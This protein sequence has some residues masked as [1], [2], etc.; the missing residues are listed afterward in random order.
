MRVVASGEPRVGHPDTPLFEC[1]RVL[2]PRT[3]DL[4]L[5]PRV[6]THLGHEEGV[7]HFVV[8]QRRDIAGV[9]HV[10]DM[11]WVDDVLG[12]DSWFDGQVAVSEGTTCGCHVPKLAGG[13]LIAQ[14]LE[15][16]RYRPRRRLTRHVVPQIDDAVALAHGPRLDTPFTRPPFWHRHVLPVRTP[17][18]PVERAH[19]AVV[20]HPAAVTQMRAEVLTG[21][22]EATHFPACRPVEHQLLTKHLE[23]LD[24][25]RCQFM[26]PADNEPTAHGHPR[27]DSHL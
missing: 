19:D 1:H 17:S 15:Q 4:A 9:V 3:V 10:A 23:G 21:R 26:R 12:D 24:I 11:N 8:D 22:L 2:P 5:T 20:D 7:S 25:T 14:V 16:I 6:H 13:V 27:R 18:P